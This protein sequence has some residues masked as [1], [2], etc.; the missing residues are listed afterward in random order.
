MR[1]RSLAVRFLVGACAVLALSDA[2]AAQARGNQALETEV[3]D[4]REAV[5]R[6]VLVRFNRP[7]GQADLAALGL[8]HDADAVES[9]G[10]GRIVRVRSRS[11]D[12]AALLAR[13]TARG[14]VSFAEPNFVVHATAQPND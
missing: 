1:P 10:A 12:V 13:L 9:I 7:L 4:G 11:I 6:E 8:E 14:D 5:T 2:A 3:I